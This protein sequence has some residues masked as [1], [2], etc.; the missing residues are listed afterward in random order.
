M[1][2]S[3]FLDLVAGVHVPGRGRRRDDAAHAVGPKCDRYGARYS[4]CGIVGRFVELDRDGFTP[5]PDRPVA[6]LIRCD[7]CVASGRFER[8]R[9]SAFGKTRAA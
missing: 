3:A 2:T 8:E 9:A 6:G 7:K 1:T 4:A 5:Y